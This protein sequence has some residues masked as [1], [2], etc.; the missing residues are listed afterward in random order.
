MWKK[1][2]FEESED[3]Q[4][5]PAAPSSKVPSSSSSRAQGAATIGPS[6]QIKGDVSG[7]EDLVIQG[8]IDGTVNLGK[9]NVTVGSDGRVKAD[10]FGRTVTVEGQV[11]GDL[12]GDEQIVLR[13][14]ARVQ[15]N[16]AAPRVTLED[17]ANFRGG[18]DMGE[19]TSKT[20]G[21]AAPSVAS[22]APQNRPSPD[23]S[24]TETSKA[25]QS[26]D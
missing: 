12:H 2:E 21:G 15:G 4:N 1:G 17:G 24:A 6:I 20:G 11:E 16:I 3:R 13:Q 7:D 8:R 19:S 14:S 5:Q 9:H 26:K 22:A 25:A 23:R 18:I 10:I